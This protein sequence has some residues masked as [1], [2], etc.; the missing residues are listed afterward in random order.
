MIF[1]KTPSLLSVCAFFALIFCSACINDAK[2]PDEPAVI[3]KASIDRD[4]FYHYSIWYAFVNKVFEGDLTVS[5]LKTKGDI[6]LGSYT[7]LDGELIMLDG[8]PYR[9]TEDGHVSIA[10]GAD[11]IVYVNTTFFDEDLSFKITNTIN[12]D[13]LRVEI[14]KQLPSK[15][16]FYAFKIHGKFKNI[17][18]GGLNK[19]EPPFK[20][21]LDVLIP[22]RPIFKAEEIEGTM[23][24]FYCPKFIGDINVAGYHLHFIS[25]DKKFGGHVMEFSAESLN[26]SI[27]EMYEYQFVL[28][29]TDA[30]RHVGF[31]KQFQYKKD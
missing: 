18:C 17:K 26:V 15:N 31:D 1:K 28:P 14:N 2:T 3:E 13:S 4:L 12:Y 21:G 22:N 19:Q 9:A 30:Y 5:K 16:M 27:D 11:K 10:K 20:E 23:V 6:G 8:I 25:D 29:N 24:G 7:K